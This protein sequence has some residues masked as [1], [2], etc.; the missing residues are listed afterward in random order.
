MSGWRKDALD[1]A[2]AGTMLRGSTVAFDGDP[3]EAFVFRDSRGVHRRIT[4]RYAGGYAIQVNFGR[5]GRGTSYSLFCSF[6]LV[7]KK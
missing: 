2:K 4:A 6:S 5:D 3:V 7:A 1:L